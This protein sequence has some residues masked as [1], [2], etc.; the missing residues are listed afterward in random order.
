MIYPIYKIGDLS[1]HWS[2]HHWSPNFQRDIP[3]W[4]PPPWPYLNFSPRSP[5]RGTPD[6]SSC[7]P[8][9]EGRVR[10]PSCPT[11]SVVQNSGEEPVEVGDVE[12]WVRQLL[13]IYN[14]WVLVEPNSKMVSFFSR[15]SEA[16][17]VS[18]L[19]L[20]N[21]WKMFGSLLR[22]LE[23]VLYIMY[24]CCFAEIASRCV[25]GSHL[26]LAKENFIIN[27]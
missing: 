1:P 19:F 14:V 10:D 7:E 3:G 20:Q 5:W 23:D 15:S 27:F 16:S 4:S 12:I 11:K 8:C 22:L 26:Y 17:I 2:D 6:F 13:D 25:K 9:P 18:G 21:C 24:T